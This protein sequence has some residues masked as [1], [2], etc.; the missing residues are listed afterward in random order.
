MTNKIDLKKAMKELV[1]APAKV[2]TAVEVPPLTDLMVDGAGDP[3]TAPACAEVVET[4]FAVAYTAKFMIKKSPQALNR[5]VVPL[6]SLWWAD[7]MAIFA[8]G[9]KSTWEWTAMI[10]QPG[11]V[12]S[13]TISEPMTEGRRKKPLQGF[14]TWGPSRKKAL[15]SNGC[16]RSSRPALRVG[17]NSM[18]SV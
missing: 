14:C 3:S 2:V 17:G 10:L 13:N 12:G 18:T 9:D 4:L 7:D 8:S 5:G 15:P 16:L 6:E 1:Q 11:F